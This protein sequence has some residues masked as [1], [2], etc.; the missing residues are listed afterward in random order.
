[1]HHVGKETRALS[2]DL[3]GAPVWQEHCR[4]LIALLG[5]PRGQHSYYKL[6]CSHGQLRRACLHGH[7]KISLLQSIAITITITIVY[8]LIVNLKPL[9]PLV[10]ANFWT[11]LRRSWSTP[12]GSWSI[13]LSVI[14]GLKRRCICLHYACISF[15][16]SLP[17][18][19]LPDFPPRGTFPP[20]PFTPLPAPWLPLPQAVEEE[21]N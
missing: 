5:V 16:L 1:M 15:R 20:F 7:A 13:P 17:A 10:V 18:V 19:L 8:H 11:N 3:L 9:K 4:I 21:R 2:D 14:K 6:R 12:P